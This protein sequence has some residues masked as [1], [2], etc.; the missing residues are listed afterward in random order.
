MLLSSKKK[1]FLFICPFLRSQRGE[2]RGCERERV[3]F[4]EHPE[5]LFSPWELGNS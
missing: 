5:F 2:G 3:S 4:F 1:I